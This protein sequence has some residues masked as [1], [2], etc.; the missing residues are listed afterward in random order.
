MLS[1]I[2]Q[3]LFLQFTSNTWVI[4]P[5]KIS[6]SSGSSQI[7]EKY[8]VQHIFLEVPVTVAAFLG[9]KKIPQLV[10]FTAAVIAKYDGAAH[11]QSQGPNK[12]SNYAKSGRT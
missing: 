12:S 3:D 7:H 10:G 4:S 1:N 9:Q 5:Q 2:K 11:I 6:L 8:T